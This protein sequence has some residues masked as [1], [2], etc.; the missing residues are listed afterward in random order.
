[1]HKNKHSPSQYEKVETVIVKITKSN[2]KLKAKD[3]HLSQ[4]REKL[5]SD[6]EIDIK[7]NIKLAKVPDMHGFLFQ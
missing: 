4:A 2:K 7:L 3:K 6:Q 1:M 5:F